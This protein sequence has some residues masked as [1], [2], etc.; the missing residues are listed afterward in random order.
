MEKYKETKYYITFDI[1]TMEELV[2]PNLNKKNK[3]K[4][5][6]KVNQTRRWNIML[7][8]QNNEE[9][10]AIIAFRSKYV[11]HMAIYLEKGCEIVDSYLKGYIILN[12]SQRVNWLRK[13]LNSR[14]KYSILNNYPNE[15]RKFLINNLTVFIDDG[16][17]SIQQNVQDYI[18]SI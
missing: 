1:E 6:E 15:I 18:F 2:S 8:N 4:S 13:N 7:F 16:D 5:K 17:L 12:R 9:K 3:V 11:K 10:E 14:A